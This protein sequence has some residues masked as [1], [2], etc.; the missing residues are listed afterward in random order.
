[1]SVQIDNTSCVAPD[2]AVFVSSVE[3]P[4]LRF[5]SPRVRLKKQGVGRAVPD[6]HPEM[7]GTA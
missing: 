1:M 4:R 7:S 5:F 6:K 3:L 2:G